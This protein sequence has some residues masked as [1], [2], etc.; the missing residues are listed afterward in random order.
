MQGQDRGSTPR[1]ST[2]E[3]AGMIQVMPHSPV[4]LCELCATPT[5]NKRFCSRRCSATVTN[6]EAPRRKKQSPL[7]KCA[8][9]VAETHNAKYCSVD[10]SIQAIQQRRAT[11]RAQLLASWLADEQIGPEVEQL[12]KAY[13][14]QTRGNKCEECG[15]AEANPVTKKVTIQMDHVNGDWQNNSISNLRLLCPNCHTLTPT[16]GALNTASM[17]AAAG[18]EPIVSR[19]DAGVRRSM[20]KQARQQLLD[21]EMQAAQLNMPA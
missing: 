5:R 11:E 7:I 12:A 13:L 4:R 8:H 18:L 21:D 19:Y 3:L 2:F 20:L 16:Y 15:W 1:V 10:C 14:I 6:S 17:R 9:C